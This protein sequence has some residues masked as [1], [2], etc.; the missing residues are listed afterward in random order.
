MTLK[1]TSEIRR[2]L[3]ESP[4]EP[5]RLIDTENNA[6]YVLVPAEQY[7]RMAQGT[8]VDE[9]GDTY[10]AQESVATAAGW[11]EPIMDDYNDH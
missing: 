1:M 11:D 2:A 8:Q 10:A 3:S 7:D 4:D 5:L 6:A 9:L